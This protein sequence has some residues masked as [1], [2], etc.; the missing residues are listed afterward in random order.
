MPWL[1]LAFCAGAAAVHFLPVL[2]TQ[3]GLL[4][5]VMAGI[6]VR[7]RWPVLAAMLFGLAWT[8]FGA[9]QIVANDWPCARDREVVDLHGVVS[10]PATMREGR[11]EFDIR[12]VDPTGSGTPSDLRLS[13]YEATAIPLPGQHW[14]MMARLR[15]RNGFSN[16]GT[17]DRELELL[18]QGIGATGYVVTG[19]APMLL[20]DLPW[21]YPVQRLRAR[22]ASDI[23]TSLSSSASAAILQG[24]SVGVRG[25]VPEKLWDAFAATGIAH[26]MA[27][28]GVHVTGC[29]LF[30]LLLLRVAWRFPWVRPRQG[31]IA[32][33]MAVV[34]MT[35]IAYAALAGASLPTLRTLVMVGIVSW[36]RVLRRAMPVH[37]SLALAAL[38]LV[39]A[40]PL[41]VSS[42]GFWLSFVATAALL[43]LIDAGPGWLNRLS[44][45][46]RE[47][48]AM[49]LLLTPVLAVAFGRLSFIAPLVNA[50][51]IPVF[52][53][54]LL[55]VILLATALTALWP[56]SAAGIWQ[57][58]ATGLDAT[59]P[60][61][62]AA[63][64]LE[65]AT[66]WPAAQPMALVITAGATAFVSLLIPLRGLRIAAAVMLMA[67]VLGRGERPAENAWILTV[68]DVGQGL[69]TIVQTRNHV[70]AFDT[71]PRWR[72]GSAAARVSLLPWL[73]AHGI[74]RID[75]L[76]LSH[77]DIDHTGGASILR[78]SLPIAE[79][80]VGPG[81]NTRG[82]STPCRRGDGWHWDGVEFQ[83]L[84]PVSGA[85]GSDN[86]NSCALR[87]NGAG[88]S[89]LLLA[90]PEA[91]AEE[92][93][94][95]QSLAADVVLVPHHGSRTSSGPR[96]IAA[97]GA[98]LG[99]V[100]A[101]FGNRWNLPDAGVIA[102]WRA[103][104]AT[105]LTTADVGAVT[106]NFAAAP[107]GIEVQAHRLESR[108]WWRRG[109]SH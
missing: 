44:A 66:W 59:W 76:V 2:P 77:D 80:I 99:I 31:R 107:G 39:A 63:G 84:H 34:V 43:S 89:A 100:S 22:I 9:R 82:A 25:N 7:P 15:C 61:L 21:Q 45:F 41:A 42:T 109:A 86:N 32:I 72:N 88:G 97:V 17:P 10:V 101:G 37:L 48:T 70:L 106:V 3:A 35:T 79:T 8:A 16:P 108:R 74:R 46:L 73:R 102:R 90:D 65:F 55:P 6:L 85:H 20:A 103:A 30:A 12:V 40:D 81:V 68:L 56:G 47:Q 60:W 67:V 23:S 18:R 1:V 98:Q 91:D 11:V 64:Q 29:A 26:L 58:L 14:R 5:T 51:A 93:L 83:M 57:T 104:G 105:V 24:L 96:L 28:S 27:I 78:E 87:V 52:S 69:A 95:S 75:R 50:I 94:L 92:E 13:W 38:L 49:L 53:F 36:Q 4:A 54:V 71:G 33:E 62:I 19:S